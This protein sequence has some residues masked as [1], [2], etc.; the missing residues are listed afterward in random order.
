MTPSG[1]LTRPTPST[2][3][4]GAVRRSRRPFFF[5]SHY[6]DAFHLSRR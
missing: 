3:L 6:S 2:N 5:L 1:V 4:T